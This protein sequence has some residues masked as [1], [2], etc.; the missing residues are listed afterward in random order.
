[1]FVTD[2]TPQLEVQAE[3]SMVLYHPNEWECIDPN[4]YAMHSTSGLCQEAMLSDTSETEAEWE[5]MTWIV[6]NGDTPGSPMCG[7]SPHFD[8][9]FLHLDM[10]DVH[11]MW[12]YRN[13]DVSTLMA[14][15]GIVGRTPPPATIWEDG[16]A[17]RALPDILRSIA[18]A[19]WFL[20]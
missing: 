11:A 5:L 9:G 8:R 16:P 10:P 2:S 13:F 12:S 20:S 15:A 17:H 6:E 14:A 18:L 1:M 19:R 3:T 7:S 4:V